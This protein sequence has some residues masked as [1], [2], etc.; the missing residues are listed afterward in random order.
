M[1]R[2]RLSDAE[3]EVSGKGKAMSDDG[4]GAIEAAAR[5]GEAH[6][7]AQAPVS[8]RR[9]RGAASGACKVRLR[10]IAVRTT[11]FNDLVLRCFNEPNLLVTAGTSQGTY[12][13]RNFTFIILRASPS[14]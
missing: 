9:G 5:A 12:T 3:S 14:A 7:A 13:Q 8:H 2:Q 4:G 1:T 10:G 11:R 6:T